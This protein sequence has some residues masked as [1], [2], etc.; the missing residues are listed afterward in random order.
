MSKLLNTNG[1][2]SKLV[3]YVPEQLYPVYKPVQWQV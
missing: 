2:F 3:Q 1:R